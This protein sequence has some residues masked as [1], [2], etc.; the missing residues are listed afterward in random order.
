M[1]IQLKRILQVIDSMN[2]G[3]AQSFVMNVYRSIDKE[4]VQ[5]DFLLTTSKKGVFDD[6]I[7]A[8]GGVI[9][10]VPSRRKGVFK[11]WKALRS[12]FE[13]HNYD[14]IHLHTSC[15]SYMEPLIA[16]KRAGVKKIILHSHSSSGPK[17]LYHK[18]MRGIYRPRIKHLATHYFACSKV[19]GE[20]MYGKYVPS[21][22][23]TVIPNGINTSGFRYSQKVNDAIRK[24]IG[25]GSNSIVV[26]HVGRFAKV[27]NHDFLIEVFKAIHEKEENSFLLLVGNGTLLEDIKKK[28][29]ELELSKVVLFLSNRDDVN[30]LMQAMDVFVMPSLYEG[31][32]VSLVEAQAT[33]LPCVV[34]NSVSKETALTK[35]ID[36]ISLDNGINEWRDIILTKSK[37]SNREKF[38]DIVKESGFDIYRISQMFERV[39]TN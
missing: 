11:N 7:E 19:A 18:V 24:S 25:V 34:S 30:K 29:H 33:G 27:K 17:G 35:L 16:A 1:V 20:W 13:S 14:C 28:V 36:F 32:P 6:E 31:L 2:L 10:R 21:E 26:G 8:L 12:F 4:K 37:T 22:N 15:P 39:Y 23:I 3:G 38:N 9:Y 5:F